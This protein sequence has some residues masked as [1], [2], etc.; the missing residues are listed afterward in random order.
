V[1]GWV[2]GYFVD[3][4]FGWLIGCLVG[5]LVVWQEKKFKSLKRNNHAAQTGSKIHISA[6]NKRAAVDK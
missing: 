5:W 3:W 2:V 6:C 4:L 1:T